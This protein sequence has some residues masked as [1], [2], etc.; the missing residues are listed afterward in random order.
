MRF[1]EPVTPY[2][3]A[4]ESSNY[5][6][7]DDGNVRGI[8]S[9]GIYIPSFLMGFIICTFALIVLS[10][11]VST[12]VINK[13]LQMSDDPCPGEWG[14][15][16]ELGDGSVYCTAE[17]WNYREDNAISQIET[18][19][20]RFKITY[21]DWSSEYR[22]ESL[23]HKTGLVVIG[24]IYDDGYMIC[25][26]YFVENELPDDFGTNDLY[27][28]EYSYYLEPSW[29]NDY[30][31]ASEDIIYSSDVP[32]PFLGVKMYEPVQWGYYEE[33][34]FEVTTNSSTESGSYMSLDFVQF[35]IEEEIIIGIVLLFVSFI[36]MLKIDQRRFVLKFDVEG[37][38]MS[39][40][41]SMTSTRWGG[42]SWQDVNYSSASLIREHNSV[43]LMMNIR[44]E[45]RL[46][47]QFLGEQADGY[48][49]PLKDLLDIPERRVTYA[50][51][52]EGLPTL[53][54][55]DVLEWDSD[56]DAKHIYDFY[57]EELGLTYD[58]KTLE[59]L[60]HGAGIRSLSDQV[61]A[62]KLLNHVIELLDPE[63]EA[64]EIIVNQTRVV[65]YT[66]PPQETDV[67]STPEATSEAPNSAQLDAFWAQDDSN[68][69]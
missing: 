40:R 42:W 41:R 53:D 49:E 27:L 38:C 14:D 58:A 21:E 55:F 28:D 3:S 26:F 44:G 30:S 66:P 9:E 65:E 11:S 29:C 35:A 64:P 6:A 36:I 47:A 69:N 60:Y 23:D 18:T 56:E 61:D 7:Y 25:R 59:E 8:K 37:K 15:V 22:W 16:V 68:G 32:F 50:Y 63:F 57:L 5:V 45:K 12:I 17:N 43:S 4:L 46:I 54:M 24:E 10:Y 1:T 20:N 31:S 34:R 19:E 62:Q 33:L 13:Q 51:A 52:Y 67:D 39:L 2:I 48:V